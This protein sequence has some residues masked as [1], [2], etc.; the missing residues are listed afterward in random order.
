M[1]LHRNEVIP[2]QCHSCEEPKLAI[3]CQLIGV[4]CFKIH[5]NCLNIN[6]NTD[7]QAFVTKIFCGILLSLQV[8][9]HTLK[10]SLTKKLR[11]FAGDIEIKYIRNCPKCTR[12]QGLLQ[13]LPL[14]WQNL[15]P[16]V[17]SDNYG[18]LFVLFLYPSA[19]DASFAGLEREM[20]K[21]DMP[22]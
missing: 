13:T 9:I 10:C 16:W 6:K 2:A 18:Y 15:H 14:L 12:L 3:K 20:K 21:E 7:W 8:K 5:K 19:G 11:I 22:L 1:S 17:S 4:F